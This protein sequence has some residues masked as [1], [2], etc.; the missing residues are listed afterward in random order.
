MPHEF[1]RAGVTG[2]EDFARLR[3]SSQPASWARI[4]SITPR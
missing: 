1:P 4:A 2:R 3:S